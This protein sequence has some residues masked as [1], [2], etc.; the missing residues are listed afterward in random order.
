[1]KSP[2]FSVII[3]AHNEEEVIEKAIKSIQEQTFRDFEIIISNDGS[4]DRTKEIVERLI[5]KDKRIKILNQDK[6]HSAAYA[7]N[8]GAEVA[9]GEI[10]I[11]LDADTFIST[12]AL[13]EMA[14]SK[15]DVQ[16]FAFDCIPRNNTLINYALSGLVVPIIAKK[17]VYSIR[18]DSPLMFFCIKSEAYKKIRGY[19]ENIFYFEDED[20]AKR[21]Y[22]AGFK[23]AYIRG[24]YQ[25]F[26]LPANFGGFIRQT[27]WIAKGLS[28][29]K[30]RKKRAKIKLFWIM[31]T[32]FL[33]IPVF[34]IFNLELLFSALIITLGSTYISL[35]LRNRNPLK[36]LVSL[37]FV[38][39]KTFLITYLILKKSVIS[40]IK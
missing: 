31:K 36:S 22:E 6:G 26:E 15:L 32:L 17:E 20:F 7:R 1:M 29:F 27:K 8:R 34:F 28:S 40:R 13:K 38:Y 3:P 9:R 2:K 33:V 16:A 11:F 12:N 37:P 10:L 5:K 24:I 35:I 19:D 39:M 25:Y 21:F 18:D 4:T 23:T 14:K 30:E